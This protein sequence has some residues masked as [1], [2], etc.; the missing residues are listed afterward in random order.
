MDILVFVILALVLVFGALFYYFFLFFNNRIKKEVRRAQKS[1]HLKSIFL[2]NASHALRVPLSDIVNFSTSILA[3]KDENLS[4][5]RVKE[6]ATQIQS[7]GRQMLDYVSQLLELSNFEDSMP[8][9]ALIEVNLGELMASYRREA[10]NLTK[11]EVSIRVRTD[12][13]PHC[14]VTLDT[15]FMHQLMMHLLADAASHTSRGEIA[16]AY[17]NERKGLKVAI[18]YPGIGHKDLM[19]DD[20]YSYL[21]SE[22][23]LKLSK[24]NSA[25]RI[26]LCKAII[27][28]L[29]GELDIEVNERTTTLSFWFPCK[30]RDQHKSR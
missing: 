14:K 9:F 28:S 30:M 25:F 13:S 19:G 29:D 15:N 26:S 4:P 17:I 12:L 16:M 11:P 2:S 18:T 21:Q 22:D 24:D 6:L 5:A 27:D 8:T 10:L 7:E 3:E 1:E 20:L 23:A